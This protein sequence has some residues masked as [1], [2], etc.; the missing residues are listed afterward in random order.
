MLEVQITGMVKY[1]SGLVAVTPALKEELIRAG[2]DKRR[3]QGKILLEINHFW[4][5]KLESGSYGSAY[6]ITSPKEDYKKIKAAVS[7]WEM[8]TGRSIDSLYYR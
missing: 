8:R 4:L 5:G 3:L 7:Q 6:H 2:V 1:G